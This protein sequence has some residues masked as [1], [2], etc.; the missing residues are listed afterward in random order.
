[1]KRLLTTACILPLLLIATA[2][3]QA[4][5]NYAQLVRPEIG[6]EGKNWLEMGFVFTGAAYPFGMVQFTS[7][8]FD[9]KK[10]FV[11]NQI[12]G[13]GC[14]Q[15][16]N[17]PVLPLTG[18]LTKSPA[19]MSNMVTTDVK[20]IKAYAGYYSGMVDSKVKAELTVTKR[21]GLARFT[22]PQE[23]EFGTVLI[24]SG[25]ASSGLTNASVTITG[26]NTVEG[27][28]EGG[29]FCQ[30]NESIQNSAYKV[31]FVA[32]FD[33]EAIESGVWDA[34]GLKKGVTIAKGK[35]SS[36][37]FTFSSKNKKVQYR[38]AISY[39]SINN[40]K[41]NLK[42]ANGNWNFDAVNAATSAD[43]NKALG[44]IEITTPSQDLKHQFYTYLYRALIH[45]NIMNDVNGE[46]IG[47]DN[48]VR[49]AEGSDYYTSYV[50]NWDTYRTQV[51]LVS[52]LFPKEAS[53]MANSLVRFAEYSNT[54]FP[55]TVL[56]NVE[57]GC[58]IG[59][60]T[61]IWVSN[62]YAFGARQFDLK[63][64]LEVMRLGA[65][66]P[67]VKASEVLGTSSYLNPYTETQTIETRHN[68]KEYL[69]KGYTPNPSLTLEYAS[70][71]FAIA[72]FALQAFN[73]KNLY[74]TYLRRANNWKNLYNPATTWLHARKDDGSFIPVG[75]TKWD[76]PNR[77][78]WIEATYKNYFWMVPFN[79]K[80]LIDT[81]NQK[82]NTL[83]E[84]RL[85]TYFTRLD[86]GLDDDW[87]SSSNEVGMFAP[88]AYCW[89]GKPYKTQQVVNRILRE[90]YS[91][92]PHGMP[93]ND[94][95]G[96]MSAHYVFSSMGLAPAIPGV[97][98][99]VINT[100]LFQSVKL[101][102][103]GGDVVIEGG[104]ETKFYTQSLKLNG[105]EYP[106]CWLPLSK[107]SKGGKLQ[108]QVA[109]KPNT[110]WGTQQRPPSFNAMPFK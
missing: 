102:L 108:F 58:M 98:G 11:I 41:E 107:I 26:K 68:L 16:G 52:L 36:A 84:K 18:K 4:Q 17:F 28:A 82:D 64:A 74:Q 87:F 59:D 8:F 51:Q 46:F 44:K 89:L 93:G 109:D 70:A 67:G 71:D 90:R 38:I 25:L 33:T 37:Y 29:S 60:P 86:A 101:K 30:P 24:G 32:E 3:L 21:T 77:T 15:L 19:D 20:M 35:N 75:P 48:K 99:F 63:K 45:P 27:T 34:E 22:F 80:T 106:S 97:G 23:E 104:S 9:G 47:S 1:M 83:A 65:E 85:D 14:G 7:S 92:T 81:I 95:A 73:N 62:A 6:T 76:D 39:V 56:V 100:P 91:N 78:P 2:N 43:W 103:P 94:D 50:S 31:Y 105:K 53:D 55:R 79:I 49:K 57:T 96:T 110:K 10:G 40:A 72:Q 54:G 61:S 66:V 13:A 88:W 69:E 12:S 5:T 42:T